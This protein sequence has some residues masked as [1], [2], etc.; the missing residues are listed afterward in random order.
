M[1]LVE[2]RMMVGRTAEQKRA[3][4]AELTRVMVETAGAKAE[5]VHVIITE[6]DGDHWAVAG[7]LVSDR[8]AETATGGAS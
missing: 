4:A 6:T 8:A 2:V 7:T 5:A 3:M 1:P